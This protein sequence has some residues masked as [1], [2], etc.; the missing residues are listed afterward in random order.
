[1]YQRST[2]ASQRAEKATRPLCHWLPDNALNTAKR[3]WHVADGFAR[4]GCRDVTRLPTKASDNTAMIS[5]TT[6]E[7]RSSKSV[8]FSS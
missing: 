8:I 7:K 1:M 3:G 4:V 2:C 5:C 6:A